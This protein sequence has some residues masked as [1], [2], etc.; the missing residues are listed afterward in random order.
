MK[1]LVTIE[2]LGNIE[3]LFTDKT[4][5][6]TEGAITSTRPSTPPLGQRPSRCCSA[7]YA[8]RRR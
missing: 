3:V 7:W 4:G 5:T 1:W 8:T 2:D 6:L